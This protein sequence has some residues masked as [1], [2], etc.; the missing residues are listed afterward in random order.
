VNNK[1]IILNGLWH[2][3][4]AIVQLLGLCPLLAVSNTFTN[5]LGLSIATM[6]TLLI[7]NILVSLLRSYIKAT[8][9][10]PIFI[11]IISCTVTTIEMIMHSLFFE[12]YLLLGIFIPLIVTN[13]IIIGRAESFASKNSFGKSVLDALAIGA[14]F[15]IVLVLLGSMREIIGSGTLFAQLNLLFG[16]IVPSSGLLIM[17]NS[18]FLL[19]ILP[20][21]AFFGLALLIFLKNLVSNE[22]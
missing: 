9:R 11:L 10:I 1:T 17:P 13:C 15:S 18:T 2:N 20:P 12:L 5:S 19:A 3:N 7:S 4:G 6:V 21:G 22:K 8:I 16:D 14:G